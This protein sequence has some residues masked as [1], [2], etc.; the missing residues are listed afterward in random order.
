MKK[1]GR[2]VCG[3]D[4]DAKHVFVSIS[5]HE[6]KRFAAFRA[7]FNALAD[8]LVANEIESVAMEAT[9][10]Y[11]VILHEVLMSRGLDVWLVDGG[12]AKQVPG[13]KTDVKDSQW[14]RELHAYGLLNRSFVPENLIRELRNFSRLREDHIRTSAMHINHMQKA[15]AQMN[16]RP[17]E[18]P[19]QVR[20]AS[21]MR[22]IKAI[23]SG[24]RRP[25]VL[26]ELC[27]GK[28][29]LT[30]REDVLKSL[31][32]HHSEYGVFALRR[33]V[34]A[35]GFHQRQISA[36]DVKLA[37]LMSKIRDGMG[38]GDGFP[39]PV[40]RRKAIRRHKPDIDDLGGAFVVDIQRWG[41]HGFAGYDGLQLASTSFGGWF[42]LKSLENGKALHFLVGLGSGASSF[43]QDEKELR[44]T[45]QTEGGFDFRK[46][47]AK[48]SERQKGGIGCFWK[49]NPLRKRSVHCHQGG[50]RKIGRFILAFD[51]KRT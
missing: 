7:D 26:V 8:F 24:E 42:G 46:C 37:E 27:R 33:A 20:G 31:E 50:G 40:G 32:G 35:H 39:K 10:V 41:R 44:T 9:G 49:K 43:G 18:V 4:M 12:S 1:I 34:E 29:L 5:G 51:G 30:K 15:L 23:L 25:E 6:V 2:D 17:K 13:R 3:I 14:I 45:R 11:W 28:T 48:P 16:I 22:I 19:S 38:E 21:G 36:C 47:G